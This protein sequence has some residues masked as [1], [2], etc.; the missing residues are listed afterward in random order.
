MDVESFHDKDAHE[1]CTIEA[2]GRDGKLRSYPLLTC[3]VA[4]LA[5]NP[6]NHHSDPETVL[7]IF[8]DLKKRAKAEGG[9]AL[10]HVR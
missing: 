10:H 6:G 9:L 4:I 5:I 8:A 3:S 7:T 2:R 1:Y